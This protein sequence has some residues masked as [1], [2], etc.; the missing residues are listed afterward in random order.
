MSKEMDRDIAFRAMHVD[1]HMAAPR[2]AFASESGKADSGWRHMRQ[3]S[4][5][6]RPQTVHDVALAV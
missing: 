2:A 6:H 1:A 4:F 5:D 3:P